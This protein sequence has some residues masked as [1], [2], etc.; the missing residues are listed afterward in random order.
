MTDRPG[1]GFLHLGYP[2]GASTFLQKEVFVPAQG[3]YN[4]FEDTAWERFL[5]LSLLR[6][7][8]QDYAEAVAGAPPLPDVPEGTMLGLS[9]ENILGQ[10]LD[11]G[12]VLA[13]LRA[14][15]GDVP[16]MIVIRKQ[17][18]LLFST[19]VN[20]LRSGYF[21][22]Y[23]DFMHQAVWDWRNSVVGRVRYGRMYHEARRHFSTVTLM[24]FEDLRRDRAGFLE[25]LSGFLGRPVADSTRQVNVTEG[26]SGVLG[27][28]I[29][30]RF[31]RHGYGQPRMSA[32]PDYVVGRGFHEDAGLRQIRTPYRHRRRIGRIVRYLDRVFPARAGAERSAVE[33]Q[34][35]ATLDTFYAEDNRALSQ[36]LGLDLGRH[37]YRGCGTGESE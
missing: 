23:A 2:K 35:A 24:V 33:A 29:G 37:G 20:S 19:Y 7:Q 26:A 5:N 22:S 11:C 8:G 27:W 31:L 34:F 3:I 21:G 30:N 17:E 13:R 4:I 10:G 15:F 28:R 36:E 9:D 6:L 32:L 18:D 1:L 14:L 16:V 12:V 25:G